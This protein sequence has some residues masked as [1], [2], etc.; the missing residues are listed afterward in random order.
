MR[1]LSLK[2]LYSRQMKV[3]FKDAILSPLEGVLRDCV[4]GEIDALHL[5]LG[6]FFLY[7]WFDKMLS[8]RAQCSSL[9]RYCPA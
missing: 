6:P 7:G 5:V 4:A 9:P 2:H 8:R 1:F 3:M